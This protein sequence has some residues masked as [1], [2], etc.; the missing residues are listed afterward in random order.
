MKFF[1]RIISVVLALCLMLSATL[2][3]SA[4]EKSTNTIDR[5]I[6]INKSA[7]Y[8]D[9]VRFCIENNLMD[10]VSNSSFAPEGTATRAQIVTVLYR[11]AGEPE[12]KNDNIFS[13]VPS[14]SYY[15]KAV[16][17]AAGKGIVSGYGNGK[18]GPDDPIIREEL[19]VIMHRYAICKEYDVSIGESTNILDYDD[20]FD[21]SSWAVSAFQWTCGTGIM[22]GCDMMLRPH[23]TATR[24]EI[25]SVLKKAY[26]EFEKMD[27]GGVNVRPI[28]GGWSINT[29]FTLAEIPQSAAAA[30][31]AATENLLG[32][33]YTPVAYLGIQ[34]VAGRNYAFLCTSTSVTAKPE[35][36][37][38]V[39]VVYQSLSGE[40]SILRINEINS[41]VIADETE[42]NFSGVKAGGW[43]VSSAVASPL[44]AAVQ[45]AFDTATGELVGVGYKPVA[46]LAS[47]VVA[48]INYAVLC[49]ATT[50]TA[51]PVTVPALVIV[52]ATPDGSAKLTHIAPFTI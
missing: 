30:F 51:E 44:P 22:S 10:G 5:F 1:I 27:N 38:C 42:L 36:G 11:M 40:S 8:F 50:V 35:T 37:L 16:V 24:A 13:D 25:A 9:S 29:E 19:A 45:K 52:Y 43:N 12:V 49:T 48:G 28:A 46:Y 34:V 47:Q 39:V 7:W 41:M 20:V 26:T 14:G 31:T 3:V 17:W 6:D 21:I 4:A 23:D 15:E 33:K 32:M 18:F 2:C